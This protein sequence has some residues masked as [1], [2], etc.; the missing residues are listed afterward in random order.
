MSEDKIKDETTDGILDFFLHTYLTLR[1]FVFTG[2]EQ[3]NNRN[4]PSTTD[5]TVPQFVMR[6]S[7]DFRNIAESN[8]RASV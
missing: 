2:D 4:A 1:G 5:F 6:T 7:R 3:E 8:S